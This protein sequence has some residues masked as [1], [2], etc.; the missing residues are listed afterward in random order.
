MS[1]FLGL[2]IF[3]LIAASFA[4]HAEVEL[5][6]FAEWIGRLPGDLLIKKK[7]MT[8]YVPLT[9]CVLISGVLSFFLSL[10]SRK[11]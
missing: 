2:A 9:S 8:L 4:I 3:L 7:G 10:F 11:N 5:P 1:Q 6:W